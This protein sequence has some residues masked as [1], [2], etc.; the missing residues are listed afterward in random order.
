MKRFKVMFNDS[1]YDLSL[2][3]R[4][5]FADFKAIN[6]NTFVFITNVCECHFVQA[7]TLKQKI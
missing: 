5:N 7:K 6:P 3:T 2:N 1:D 4:Y